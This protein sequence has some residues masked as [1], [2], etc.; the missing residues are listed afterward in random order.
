[1]AD[2]TPFVPATE[3]APQTEAYAKKD[4]VLSSLET[5]SESLAYKTILETE[6]KEEKEDSFFDFDF[7]GGDDDDDDRDPMGEKTAVPATEYKRALSSAKLSAS[8]TDTAMQAHRTWS[9]KDIDDDIDKA[10]SEGI[11]DTALDV[12]GVTLSTVADVM[13]LPQDLIATTSLWQSGTAADVLGIQTDDK[14]GDYLA[15]LAGDYTELLGDIYQ[16]G[17]MGGLKSLLQ[18]DAVTGS[19][20]EVN[21]ERK[22]KAFD[23]AASELARNIYSALADKKLLAAA[24]ENPGYVW[25]SRW[26]PT[27]EMFLDFMLPADLAIRMSNNIDE[28]SIFNAFLP[29]P[30][31]L[32]DIGTISETAKMVLDKAGYGDSLAGTVAK[33]GTYFRAPPKTILKAAS[34]PVGR[35]VLGLAAE[36]VFDP[37]WFLGPAKGAVTVV[38]GGKEFSLMPK[39]ASVAGDLE[40]LSGKVGHGSAFRH[41]VLDLIISNRATKAGLEAVQDA[42]KVA[43]R[44]VRVGA[45]SAEQDAKVAN[46]FKGL[47]EQ[48]DS[49]GGLERAKLELTNL[50]KAQEAEL[51]AVA[52]AKTT[53]VRQRTLQV[54]RKIKELTSDLAAIESKTD[55]DSVLKMLKQIENK[56]R[57]NAK[58][59]KFKL[60]QIR[61][62]IELTD[63]ATVSNLALEKGMPIIGTW[64]IPLTGKQVEVGAELSGQ[65]GAV[66]S[67]MNKAMGTEQVLAVARGAVSKAIRPITYSGLQAKKIKNTLDGLPPGNDLNSAENFLD[68]IYSAGAAVK[69]TVYDRG[70]LRGLDYLGMMFGTRRFHPFTVARDTAFE[71][72]YYGLRE[73]AFMLNTPV[74]NRPIMRIKRVRPELWDNYQEAVTNYIRQISVMESELTAKAGRVY[75]TAKGALKEYKHNSAK[76]IAEIPDEVSTLTNELAQ[77]PKRG[78]SREIQARRIAI[79]KQIARLQDEVDDLQL[80]I[81]DGY[82]V[83]ALVNDVA[84]MIEEGVGKLDDNPWLGVVRTEWIIMRD[85]LAIKLKKSTEEIDQAI[86]AMARFLNG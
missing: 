26:N 75:S 62:F 19:I 82:G 69:G 8:P 22:N 53:D 28:H 39:A 38:K 49:P 74:A 60:N 64:H 11:I 52:K 18:D 44:L 70:F 54:Q 2:P 35:M 4:P 23:E 42:K 84:S 16:F 3:S 47:A 9:G 51:S 56:H 34:D 27:G 55:S 14:A 46:K 86:V 67:K 73:S 21:T 57:Y 33:A 79:R 83:N 59:T 77:L 81:S 66:A 29:A 43:Y 36:V 61:T 48:V 31:Q 20:E 40:G 1:M 13:E 15:G 45:E 71:I 24:M 63:N 65:I 80:V 50:I 32:R 58:A 7:F 12:A 37:L 85:D 10:E 78:G 68:F 72:S 17:S 5:S 76:R 25:S 41:V 30:S 6:P